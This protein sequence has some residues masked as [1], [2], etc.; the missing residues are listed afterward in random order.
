V[1]YSAIPD[2]FHK[3]SFYTMPRTLGEAF[4]DLYEQTYPWASVEHKVGE[5]GKKPGKKRFFVFFMFLSEA[6]YIFP[7]FGKKRFLSFF[8]VFS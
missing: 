7:F 2:P 3:W 5:A 4:E 8:V 6:S 1:T